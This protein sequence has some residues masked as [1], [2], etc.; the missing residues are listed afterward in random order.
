MGFYSF[1]GVG[2]PFDP[3]LRLV[4]SYVISPSAL[5]FLRALF[6]LYSLV[7]L[8]VNVIYASVVLDTGDAWPTY[9]TNLSYVGL[10]AYFCAATVQSWSY[11]Q[12]LKRR[13]QEHGYALQR[14]HPFLQ[15]SHIVLFSTIAVCRELFYHFIPAVF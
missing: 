15:F 9:F 2:K 13:S 4:T 14:W 11:V 10:C 12:S 5:L 6:A 1:F 3:E 8:I 7:S